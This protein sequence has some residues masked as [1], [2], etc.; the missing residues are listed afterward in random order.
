MSWNCINTIPSPSWSSSIFTGGSASCEGNSAI[1]IFF[2]GKSVSLS[3][4]TASCNGSMT[5]SVLFEIAG[6]SGLTS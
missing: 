6:L 3:T 2:G 1:V 4:I 5:G